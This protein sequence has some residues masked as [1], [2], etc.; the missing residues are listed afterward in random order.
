MKLIST[1]I[2]YTKQKIIDRVP[3][4]S[5]LETLIQKECFFMLH[6]DLQGVTEGDTDPKNR[7]ISFKVTTSNQG[8]APGS[9]WLGGAF[10]KD[11][12]N[13]CKIKMREMKTK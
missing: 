13:V 2:K 3:S 6:L 5:L 9:S 10:L 11:Y 1:M 4:F 12:K 7:F 8:I